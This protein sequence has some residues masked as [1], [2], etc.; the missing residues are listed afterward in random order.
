MPRGAAAALAAG[1]IM[2]A[3]NFSVLSVLSM[4]VLVPVAD[5]WRLSLR[6]A[7]PSVAKSVGRPLA[8]HAAST[9]TRARRPVEGFTLAKS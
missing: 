4:I 9:R 6:L 1:P 3:T 8:E 2:V 5:R 7:C